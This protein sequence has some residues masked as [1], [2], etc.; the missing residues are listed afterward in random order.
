MTHRA[1]MCLAAVLAAVSVRA[2]AESLESASLSALQFRERFQKSW[3]ARPPQR[4]PRKLWHD[5][6]VT[7][8]Q[9]GFVGPLLGSFKLAERLDAHRNLL[10]RQ[11]GASA[12]D[13]SMASDDRFKVQYLHLSKPGV[14]VLKRIDDLNRL[15]GDGVVVDADAQTHYRVKVSINIFSPVRGSTVNLDPVNGTKGP[16]HKIKTGE[17]L[18]QVKGHSY[19]FRAGGKEFWLLYGTDVDPNTDRF[20]TTRSLVFVNEAGLDSKAWPVSESQLAL[21]A[22]VGVDLGGVLLTLVR[23]SDGTLRIHGR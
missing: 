9:P 1:A 6:K 7:P 4:P 11:L 14:S 23:A 19:V 5:P 16:A 17:V 2:G 12:W 20:T 15:R 22:Q 18:D 13:I 21:D 10:N 3:E 8:R